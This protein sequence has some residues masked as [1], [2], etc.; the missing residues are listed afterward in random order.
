MNEAH[1][2]GSKSLQPRLNIAGG[3]MPLPAAP[4]LPAAPSAPAL[5]PAAPALDAAGA[6]APPVPALALPAREPPPPAVDVGVPLRA[7]LPVPDEAGTTGAVLLVEPAW[8]LIV[9]APAPALVDIE[10]DSGIAASP[11]QAPQS[12]N[13]N[14]AQ[15]AAY[16]EDVGSRSRM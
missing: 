13:P 9:T 16:S 15:A 4:A 7:T 2:P 11:P 1:G 10:L 5:D 3:I 8:L 14:A 12:R 6:G